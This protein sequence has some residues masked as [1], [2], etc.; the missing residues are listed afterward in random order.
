[1]PSGMP[2]WLALIL[3]GVFAV[4]AIRLARRRYEG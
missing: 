1:M 4:A 2:F 3:T